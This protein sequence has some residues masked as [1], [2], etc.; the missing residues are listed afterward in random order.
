MM[1]KSL[2]Q[3]RNNDLLGGTLMRSELL[4]LDVSS[5]EVNNW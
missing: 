5:S 3:M 2:R 4:T 1:V